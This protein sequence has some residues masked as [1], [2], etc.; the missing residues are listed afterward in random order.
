MEVSKKF[1]DRLTNKNHLVRRGNDLGG[2]N[3]LFMIGTNFTEADLTCDPYLISKISKDIEGQ[4][5]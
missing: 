1:G 2:M 3:L 4:H 5:F